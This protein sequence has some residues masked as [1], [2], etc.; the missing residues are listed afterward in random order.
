MR[1]LKPFIA[2]GLVGLLTVG[3]AVT[4]DKLDAAQN[5]IYLERETKITDSALFFDGKK[6]K[7]I[8]A[9]LKSKNDPNGTYNYMYGSAI[10]PHG[11]AIKTYKHSVFMAWYRGGKYDRHIKL[12]GHVAG[13]EKTALKRLFKI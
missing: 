12:D 10:S 6:M 8:H 1:N 5:E 2:I 13:A 7:D 9:A 11:D 4:E 3:C